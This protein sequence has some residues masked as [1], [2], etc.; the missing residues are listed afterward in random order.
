V[1]IKLW[2]D[3]AQNFVDA[4]TGEP[5]TADELIELAVA[6]RTLPADRQTVRQA[7]VEALLARQSGRKPH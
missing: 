3:D 5:L 2:S 6:Y 1:S 7:Y 4:R